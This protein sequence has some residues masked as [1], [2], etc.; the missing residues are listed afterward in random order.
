[1]LS[2][3][4]LEL[5]DL[6]MKLGE[7]LNNVQKSFKLHLDQIVFDGKF[8]QINNGSQIELL[9]DVILM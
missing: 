7:L 8:Y 1:M 9:H 2:S 6:L 5:R 4:R 3:Q